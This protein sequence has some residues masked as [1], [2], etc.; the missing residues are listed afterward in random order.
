MPPAEKQLLG[1]ELQR[2]GKTVSSR[3][4]KK[5]EV[6]DWFQ[7]YAGWG[8]TV[9]PVRRALM[10]SACHS[11]ANQREPYVVPFER[12]AEK[13]TDTGAEEDREVGIA[14]LIA[15]AIGRHSNPKPDGSPDQGTLPPI[16]APH[17]ELLHLFGEHNTLLGVTHP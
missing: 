2:S 5:R 11:N 16:P 14:G 7:H 15:L 1:S 4:G 8:R 3:K 6:T 17:G 9:A 13:A 10:S 12:M